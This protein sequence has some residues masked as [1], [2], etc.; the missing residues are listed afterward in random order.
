MVIFF[1]SWVVDYLINQISQQKIWAT[2][3]LGQFFNLKTVYLNF[4]IKF[5]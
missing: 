4:L 1:T 3:F 5:R 2:I